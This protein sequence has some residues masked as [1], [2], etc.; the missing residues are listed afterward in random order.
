M[1]LLTDLS[2]WNFAGEGIGFCVGLAASGAAWGIWSCGTAIAGTAVIS[3]RIAMRDIMNLILCEVIAIYG[4]IMAL[5]L[6]G[7][8]EFSAPP[9][10]RQH[11]HAGYALFFGGLVQGSCSFS[12]GLAIGIVG[13]T[14]SIVCHRD[15]ELFFKLLIVQIFSELIG[16]MGLLV[17]LL[18]SMRAQFQFVPRVN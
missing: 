18:T 9:F 11:Y 7:R 8:M 1:G 4:L 3:G 17:C 5:V 12:A 15:A 14:I 6:N 16:I 2:P 10:E 13:S